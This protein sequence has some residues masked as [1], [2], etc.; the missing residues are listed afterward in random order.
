[1]RKLWIQSPKLPTVITGSK[2][3]RKGK[4]EWKKG[5]REVRGR[6]GA[7][8]RKAN[9]QQGVWSAGIRKEELRKRHRDLEY[10]QQGALCR[11][12]EILC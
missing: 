4:I 2:E 12:T 8:E 7:R 1:M 3:I 6:E 11:K 9:R 5:E 10:S